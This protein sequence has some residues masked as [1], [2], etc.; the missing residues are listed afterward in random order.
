[1]M[2]VKRVTMFLCDGLWCVL[3]EFEN[4][5]EQQKF[6]SQAN[7]MWHMENMLGRMCNNY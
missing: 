1:M 5:T 7:A 6:P 3:T 2:K 4:T